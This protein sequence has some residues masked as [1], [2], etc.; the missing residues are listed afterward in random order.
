MMKNKPTPEELETWEKVFKPILFDN[1]GLNKTKLI[2]ML[3]K[4]HQAVQEVIR[5]YHHVTGGIIMDITTPA[6]KV[7]ETITALDNQNLE[8]I[9]KDEKEK[10]LKEQV[11][12]VDDTCL[13][14]LSSKQANGF[15]T[16]SVTTHGNTFGCILNIKT[17]QI[18]TANNKPLP[19]EWHHTV[20]G[21]VL[22]LMNDSSQKQLMVRK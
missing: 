6:A 12:Q 13:V 8:G 22:N 20:I 3:A 7:I 16:F 21:A 4:H 17:N 5:V 19:Q 2:K 9:L 1:K 11:E 14:K 10:W 18:S 15:V